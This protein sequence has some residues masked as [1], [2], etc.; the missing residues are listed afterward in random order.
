MVLLLLILWFACVAIIGLGIGATV[1]WMFRSI[2][3]GFG[4]RE[5]DQWF[6][7]PPRAPA[8][9][10]SAY[11]RPDWARKFD[12]EVRPDWARK[13]DAMVDAKLAELESQQFLGAFPAPKP[14]TSKAERVRVA[15]DAIMDE[16]EETVSQEELEA[17]LERRFAELKKNNKE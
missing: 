7:D 14:V 6:P 15:A 4:N 12:A 2:V 8:P 10:R 16:V 3:K 5:E 17:E 13:L 9:P 11:D 1:L